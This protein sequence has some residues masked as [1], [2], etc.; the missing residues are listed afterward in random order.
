MAI[1]DRVILHNGAG[2][3]KKGGTGEA[4]AGQE[5]ARQTSL[6][7]ATGSA[8]EALTVT[9]SRRGY[10]DTDVPGRYRPRGVDLY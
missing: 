6:L 3:L 1:F 8:T 10:R 5:T 7:P 9:P 4:I 2:E